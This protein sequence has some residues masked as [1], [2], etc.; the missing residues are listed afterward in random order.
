MKGWSGRLIAPVAAV[1]ALAGCGE[2]GATGP[3]ADPTVTEPTHATDLPFCSEVW[4][5]G[6]I[7]PASYRGC[8]EDG[9]SVKPQRRF[10]S[11]GQKIVIYGGR[12]Y[13]VLGHS[14]QE[15]ESLR[16]DRDFRRTMRVCQG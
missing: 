9:R 2:D 4:V 14:V 8:E 5:A 13:A 12:F 1:A 16:T 15:T 11:S 7:L 3:T 10:C 6:A